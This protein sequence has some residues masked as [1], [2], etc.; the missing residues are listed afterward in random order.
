MVT[1]S[2]TALVLGIPGFVYADL[3][4]PHGL[5]RLHDIW[6]RELD[7]V[8]SQKYAAYQAGAAFSP[9]EL[10]ALL[11]ELAATMTPFLTRLFPDIAKPCE[12]FVQ[13]AEIDAA[14]F[15]EKTDASKRRANKQTQLPTVRPDPALPEA[16]AEYQTVLRTSTIP[17]GKAELRSAAQQAVSRLSARLGQVIVRSPGKPGSKKACEEVTMW[18]RPGPALIKVGGK[19]EPIEVRSQAVTHVGLCP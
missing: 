6:R 4:S 2:Q 5:R 1:T 13:Q 14:L 15:R 9:T 16:M 11:C 3:F 19:L 12:A 17:R 10:S 8:L 7:P 18:M